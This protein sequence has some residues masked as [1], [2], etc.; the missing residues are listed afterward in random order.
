MRQQLRIVCRI[1]SDQMRRQRGLRGAQ[2]PD[3]QVVHLDYAGQA[4]QGALDLVLIY[5][6][7]DCIERQVQRSGQQGPRSPDD[8]DLDDQADRWVEPMPSSPQD[9]TARDDNAQRLQRV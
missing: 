8:D 2:A 5:A 4:A 3:V 9:K 7:G 1:I 6:F